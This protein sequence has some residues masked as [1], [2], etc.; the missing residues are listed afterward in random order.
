MN[1]LIVNGF[2]LRTIVLAG[3]DEKNTLE[4]AKHSLHSTSTPR[5]V[6][7]PEKFECRLVFKGANCLSKGRLE[8]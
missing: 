6:G 7:R 1:T 5:L 2:Y 8:L 3:R 4:A